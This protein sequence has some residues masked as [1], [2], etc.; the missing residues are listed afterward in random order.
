MTRTPHVDKTGLKKGP[1]S[2]EEDDKLKAYIERYGHWNWREIPR[3]AGKY[4]ILFL[5]YGVWDCLRWAKIAVE[6]PGRSDNEIKN[7]WNTHLKKLAKNDQND[8]KNMC[9]ET[10]NQ[11]NFIN[12][13]MKISSASSPVSSSSSCSSSVELT[14]SVFVASESLI[15]SGDSIQ[16]YSNEYEDG[17]FWTDPFYADLDAVDNVNMAPGDNDEFMWSTM[18]LYSE[19]HSRFMI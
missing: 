14:S 7:Y 1:W 5:V 2:T 8:P 9:H 11:T 3:F 13:L 12:N 17:N 4:P 19:Y 16:A 10:K 18:D 15:S 6:L